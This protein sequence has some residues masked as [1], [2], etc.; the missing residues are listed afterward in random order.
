MTS[1]DFRRSVKKSQTPDTGQLA[2]PEVGLILGE[3]L[4]ASGLPDKVLETLPVTA[5]MSTLSF[6]MCRAA[7]LYA[8]FEEWSDLVRMWDL[9]RE[10][11][12]QRDR[13]VE[14]RIIARVCATIMDASGFR[15]VSKI[16]TRSDLE[17]SE[18]CRYLI[19]SPLGIPANLFGIRL[20]AEAEA[21]MHGSREDRVVAFEQFLRRSDASTINQ[22]SMSFMLGYLASRIAPGTIRHSGVLGP[23]ANRYPTS[24]LWYGF[25]SA[26][27]EA[28]SNIRHATR[29]SGVDFPLS[30]RRV[31][32]ELLRP[33][34]VLSVPGCDIGCLELLALSRTAGNPLESVVRMNQ[35]SVTV[36]LLPCVCTSVNVSSKP[37]DDSQV[38]ELLQRDVMVTLGQQIERLRE[39]YKRLLTVA[40]PSIEVEQYSMFPSGRKKK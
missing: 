37:T 22:E 26:F 31:F 12:K 40:T 6:V 36:E 25:C 18:A 17:V 13:S 14:S 32:R 34:P 8:D 24:M 10:I 9:V 27:G 15:G 1:A 23:I 5:Y 2:W 20:F 29:K 21:M 38:R 7:A 28:E 11:S 4:M 30:A 33:E 35:G 3:V 16:L 39:T 19:K